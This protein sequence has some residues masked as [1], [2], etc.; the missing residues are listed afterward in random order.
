[1][2]DRGAP[3]RARGSESADETSVHPLRQPDVVSDRPYPPN[4]PTEQSR[5]PGRLL[6]FRPPPSVTQEPRGFQRRTTNHLEP[7]NPGPRRSPDTRTPMSREPMSLDSEEPG[8]RSPGCHPSVAKES[9][10]PPVCRQRVPGAARLP[11][12][13]PGYTRT[14]GTTRLSPKKSGPNTSLQGRNGWTS[15][16][17]RRTGKDG[18]RRVMFCGHGVSSSILSG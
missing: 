16:S 13:S 1:M 6:L 9:R 5:L 4:V 10:A 15:E 2:R 18:E 14:Q 7:R 17:R 3:C 8:C 12:K 11:S